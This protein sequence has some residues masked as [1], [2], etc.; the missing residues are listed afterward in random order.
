MKLL[1]TAIISVLLV[2]YI[3][4]GAFKAADSFKQQTEE[5][6]RKLT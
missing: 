2:A 5:R 3:C 1:L 6:L 4:D